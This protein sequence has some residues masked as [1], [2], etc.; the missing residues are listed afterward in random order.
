MAYK[1]CDGCNGRKVVIGLGMIEKDCP[2]CAGVG[3]VGEKDKEDSKDVD[4]KLDI[5]S[6]KDA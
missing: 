4:K 2:V 1:R 3:Y 6:K 5:K